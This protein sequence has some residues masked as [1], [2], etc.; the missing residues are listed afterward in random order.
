MTEIE[1]SFLVARDPPAWGTATHIDQGYLAVGPDGTEVCI[2][3]RGTELTLTVK[4]G[5]AGRTRVE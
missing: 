3:R 4:G 5:D 1:R 2:R